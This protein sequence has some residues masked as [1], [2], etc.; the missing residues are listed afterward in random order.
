MGFE[1]APRLLV[2]LFTARSRTLLH[3]PRRNAE[4]RNFPLPHS[5][6]LGRIWLDNRKRD[7]IRAKIRPHG[8]M[9][10][11]VGNYRPGHDLL[12][13]LHQLKRPPTCPHAGNAVRSNGS[14]RLW[15]RNFVGGRMGHRPVRVGLG[16]SIHMLNYRFMSGQGVNGF[17]TASLSAQTKK[18]ANVSITAKCERCG[19]DCPTVGDGFG[20]L[21]Q[22]CDD[23]L[24][25]LK[26]ERE[27]R[28]LDDF[29]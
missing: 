23:Y 18:C 19:C 9:P 24:T 10:D 28:N 3:Q 14:V 6:A 15:S 4:H 17:S 2:H 5:V 12:L 7:D 20:W 8:S 29:D 26:L 25:E 13:A 16:L 11:A 1:A 22:D 21:C 27:E